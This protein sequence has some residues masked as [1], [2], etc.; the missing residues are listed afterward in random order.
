M[1]LLLAPY[2]RT[3]QYSGAAPYMIGIGNHEYD[4]S[5]GGTGKDP[6]GIDTDGSFSP[7]WGN[8]GNDG[9]GE[10]GVPMDRRFTMPSNGNGV[11]WCE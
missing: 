2:L 8:F 9:G 4:H 7:S 1:V 6:S 10:C 11:F 3:S 5:D